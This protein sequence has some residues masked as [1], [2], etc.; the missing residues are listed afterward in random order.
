MKHCLGIY[1]LTTEEL[2][3]NFKL[4]TVRLSLIKIQS[5]PLKKKSLKISKTL[6][7]KMGG[8]EEQLKM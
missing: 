6:C 2:F 7:L 8:G 4:Y 1:Y 5:K 3:K